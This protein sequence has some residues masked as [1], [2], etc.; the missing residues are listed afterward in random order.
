MLAK[1]WLP[2]AVRSAAGDRNAGEPLFRL[3]DKTARLYEVVAGRVRLTRTGE[4]IADASLFS[5]AYHW[6]AI[7]GSDA[8]VQVYRKAAVLT[9]FAK[10]RKVAQAF[11]GTLAHQVMGLRT[12]PE[13]RNIGSARECLHHY[14]ALNASADGGAVKLRGTVKDFASEFDLT[15]EALYRAL[16]ALERDMELLPPTLERRRGKTVH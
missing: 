14:L 6:D 10:D 13:Q 11:T 4:T 2:A 8:V 5:L 12:C 3:G 7:A 1:D 9:A 15:H 16:A